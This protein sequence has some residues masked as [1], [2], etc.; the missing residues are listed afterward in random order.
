MKRTVLMSVSA[1]I[2]T[3]LLSVTVNSNFID[4][5]SSSDAPVSPALS[6]I[7]DC[8]PMAKAGIVG[9]EIL[10]T[11][12]DFE[13]ALNV[14]RVSTVTV[15]SLPDVTDGELLIGSVV[16]KEGQ[17]ISRA[18]LSL[19]SYAAVRED[20]REA[21]FEFQVNGQPYSMTCSLYLLDGVNHSPTTARDGDMT[22]ST[23]RDVAAYGKL[24]AYD[25]EG[26]EL[27]Y[28]IVSY[29]EHGIALLY[30]NEGRYVY[31]PNK[32]FTGTDSLSYVVYDKYGNYSA[33]STVRLSVSRNSTSLA[34]D[35]MKWHTA[36]S[37]AIKLAENGVMNG[38]QVAGIYYFEPDGTVTRGE[39]V[40]MAMKAAGVVS[41][42]T[43]ENTGFADDA[44]I[45]AEMKSYIGMAARAGYVNGTLDGA[46]KYFLPDREITVAEAA[47]IC[48]NI[49]ELEYDGSIAVSVDD[50]TIPASAREAV[51]SLAAQGIIDSA[52]IKDYNASVTRA[53]AAIMLAA[54]V[55]D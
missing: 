13:R 55:D 16:V 19:L 35:D 42:P 7:A 10:F 45:P 2:V 14:S 4:A 41:L 29:P 27:T 34:Y 17:T 24:Y 52:S 40:V 54:L 1:L 49:L 43:V 32:D 44:D 5:A 28:Q 15:T 31:M 33:V 26:D 47:T 48:A 25:P 6:I 23:Y 8:M 22:V 20:S 53:D 38:T 3:L 18:N 11:P 36:Y 12:E 50:S 51:L 9:N 46:N 37:A 30:D 39:F 21:E